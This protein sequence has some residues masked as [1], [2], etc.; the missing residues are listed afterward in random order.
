MAGTTTASQA[1]AGDVLA[2]LD[3]LSPQI[4]RPAFGLMEPNSRQSSLGRLGVLPTPN[5]S[6]VT[7]HQ[8]RDRR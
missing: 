3:L 7:W 6:V 2:S 1:L 4:E 5:A 8:R